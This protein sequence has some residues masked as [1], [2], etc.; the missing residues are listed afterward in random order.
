MGA[1]YLEAGV[2]R[3]LHEGFENGVDIGGDLGVFLL[4][5]HDGL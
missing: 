1:G 4:P 3:Q 2:L 5:D